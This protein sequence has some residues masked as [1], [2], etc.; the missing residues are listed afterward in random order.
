MSDEEE[1]KPGYLCTKSLPDTIALWTPDRF[2]VNLSC[3]AT[4]LV[5]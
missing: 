5:K 1:S 4:N 2:S 3:F